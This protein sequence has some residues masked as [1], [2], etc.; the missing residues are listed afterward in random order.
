MI[1]TFGKF[2]ALQ[3][4]QTYSVQLHSIVKSFFQTLT[5]PD[6]SREELFFSRLTENCAC[7][8]TVAAV[9]GFGLG[10]LFGLF[11][12]SVDP[13]A[14]MAAGAD[15]SKIVC[16]LPLQLCHESRQN[17]WNYHCRPIVVSRCN[18]MPGVYFPIRP[19]R[20]HPTWSPGLFLVTSCWSDWQQS[21]LPKHRN[22]CDAAYCQLGKSCQ[23]INLPCFDISQ[24]G[25]I[26]SNDE[27][28]RTNFFL[29]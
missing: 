13:Q 24:V 15:P 16:F 22:E 4:F 9:A 29:K 27:I 10:I 2:N 5:L 1:M 28:C 3:N 18:P 17:C 14:T 8:S 19:V 20:D 6:M 7:K 26:F 21:V 12:A 23:G 11:T 25:A